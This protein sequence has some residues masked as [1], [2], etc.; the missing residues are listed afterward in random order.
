MIRMLA[1]IRHA[2][3][4]AAAEMALVAPLLLIIMMGS[5]EL[6]NY[7]LDEHRLVKS[8]RDGARFAAR[9]SFTNYGCSGAIGGTVITDTKNV[10]MTGLYSGG[11]ARLPGWTA[12]TIT[13]SQTCTTSANGTT[14]S[15]IYLS[16]A[17]GAPIVTVAAT[18]PYTSILQSFG[19]RGTGL[20]L[21]A[22]QQAAVMGL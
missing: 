21:N 6:G 11:S 14:L 10:V 3:G 19:F 1:L 8:V 17:N 16:S 13:V 15:G 18:V 2:G 12:P 4:A 5:M 20:N 22:N 7:F 9:Q